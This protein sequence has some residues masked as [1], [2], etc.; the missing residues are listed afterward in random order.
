MRLKELPFIF[1]AGLVLWVNFFGLNFALHDL[2]KAF[3]GGIAIC[4]ISIVANIML[5]DRS[6][7]ILKRIGEHKKDALH[8]GIVL[9]PL[10][11]FIFGF[12]LTFLNILPAIYSQVQI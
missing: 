3:F 8:W 10:Y 6:K 1:P 4:T 11:G 2:H 5:T 9:V 12:L 7:D